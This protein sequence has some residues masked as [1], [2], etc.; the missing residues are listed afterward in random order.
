MRAHSSHH[1]PSSLVLIGAGNMGSAMLEG[2]LKVGINRATTT[3]LDPHPSLEVQTLCA[4][5]RIALNPP[6]RDI[7]PPQAVVLATKPQALEAVAP[8]VDRLIGPETLL[9]SILAG[10]RIEDLKRAIPRAKAVVRAMP[11]LAAAVRLSATA[12]AA[13]EAVTEPQRLIAHELLSSIG[14]VEWVGHERLIDAVTAVSGS[15]PAYF[16]YLTECLAHAGTAAGLPTELAERLAR[17]TIIG[18]GE[19]L[20]QGDLP[21]AKLRHNVT[22]PGGTTAAAL[23]VLMREPGLRELIREAVDAAKRRAEELSG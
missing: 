12:A 8:A 11:N 9:V 19:L 15:G 2:W 18:A 4:E 17:A 3:V 22:S 23:D 21:P 6:V 20:R 13:S 10:K 14:Q 16:F 5:E 1:L 7:R